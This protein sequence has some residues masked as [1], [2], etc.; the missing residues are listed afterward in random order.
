MP[1]KH[2]DEACRWSMP[3][4]HADG[5]C[6]WGMLMRT[7]YISHRPF[8]AGQLQWT[9][10]RMCINMPIDTSLD[11][12][13][14]MCTEMCANKRWDCPCTVEKPAL[15]WFSRLPTGLCHARD[16]HLAMPIHRHAVGDAVD[17]VCCCYRWCCFRC[18]LWCC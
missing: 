11:M 6:L 8:S 14:D 15:R 7:W 2:A 18:S 4:E 12:C 9:G 10:I 5:A 17:L 13:I 1:M 3:M 16:K